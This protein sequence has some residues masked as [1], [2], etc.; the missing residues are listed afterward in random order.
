MIPRRL[1][2]LV[3]NDRDTRVAVSVAWLHVLEAPVT[4]AKIDRYLD[5]PRRNVERAIDVLE[6]EGLL[7]VHPGRPRIIVPTVGLVRW[8]E[9]NVGDLGRSRA[10]H[11][12][13]DRTRCRGH[14]RCE[15]PLPAMFG[16]LCTACGE[17]VDTRAYTAVSSTA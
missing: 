13:I 4:T 1:T 6:R 7:E 2:G 15:H 16:S 17:T 9:P 14:G 12:S 10:A 11:V 3:L 5:M 8:E